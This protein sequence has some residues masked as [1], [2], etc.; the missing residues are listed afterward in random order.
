MGFRME[1]GQ[2]VKALPEG[3]SIPEAAPKGLFAHNIKEFT[4]LASILPEIYAEM[5]GKIE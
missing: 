3:A 2:I 4:N 5:E 1:N